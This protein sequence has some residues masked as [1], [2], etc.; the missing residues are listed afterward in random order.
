MSK[1]ILIGA[2][3]LLFVSCGGGNNQQAGQVMIPE[4]KV[5]EIAPQEVVLNKKYPASMVGKDFV[6][7]MP[8]VSG[9]IQEIVV[10]E[11]ST[12]KKG[13]VIARISKDNYVQETRTALASMN[14]AK[15]AVETAKLELEKTQSLFDS[16][17]VSKFD[18]ED[19]KLNLN[20]KNAQYE[21]AKAVYDNAM[22]NLDFTEIKSPING[23]IGIYS[24]VVGTLVS[25]SGNP[26]TTISSMENMR[27]YFSMSDVEYTNLLFSRDN[28]V[29]NVKTSFLPAKFI[30]PN[31]KEYSQDGLL[32]VIS[33]VVDQST[34]SVSMRATFS[35]DGTLR[36]GSSGYVIL[37]EKFD[38]VIIIPQSATISLQ[39]KIVAYVVGPDS[40]IV[41][42][43]V[44]VNSTTSGDDFVVTKG[45]SFGDKII[46]EN[47]VK[48]REGM[49]VSAKVD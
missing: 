17:I 21:Q 35:N 15:V 2:M 26:I 19:A 43:F 25:P 40:T 3:L 49:K 28:N 1:K 24:C 5:I 8:R 42:K 48:L 31:G 34:G 22:V 44:T 12:V 13:Q 29:K 16:K 4:V 20:M 23:V 7:V 9:Y 30:M 36:G 33:G 47:I 39:D 6:K 37:P 18:L 14:V 38:S 46:V 27:A 10:E 45:L 11:G 41:S 32:D